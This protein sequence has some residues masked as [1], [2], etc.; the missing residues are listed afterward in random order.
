MR[1]ESRISIQTATMLVVLSRCLFLP[2]QKNK[3]KMLQFE[4]L[5]LLFKRKFPHKYTFKQIKRNKSK[6]NIL[7]TFWI[8]SQAIEFSNWRIAHDI[9]LQLFLILPFCDWSCQ[10]NSHKVLHSFGIRLMC[11]EVLQIGLNSL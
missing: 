2:K 11:I 4:L 7:N 10:S 1:F 8:S 3:Q 6:R 9:L 5:F